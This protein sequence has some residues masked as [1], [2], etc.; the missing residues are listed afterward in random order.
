MMMGSERHQSSPLCIIES[1]YTD[2][3][4]GE[5]H[6]LHSAARRACEAVFVCCRASPYSL[7]PVRLHVD[8]DLLPAKGCINIMND[9]VCKLCLSPLSARKVVV[10]KP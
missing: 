7:V 6:L 8:D 5:A 1:T 3:A 10:R 4:R 2:I 9:T